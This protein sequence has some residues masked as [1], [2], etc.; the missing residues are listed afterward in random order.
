[1]EKQQKHR[2][3]PEAEMRFEILMIINDKVLRL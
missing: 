3:N 2:Y 1:M